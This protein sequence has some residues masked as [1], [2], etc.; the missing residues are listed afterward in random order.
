MKWQHPRQAR[1]PT[2]VPPSPDSLTGLYDALRCRKAKPYVHVIG[3]DDGL[4]SVWMSF[5][6]VPETIT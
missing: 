4:T 6:V 3:A 1:G 2:R 5:G